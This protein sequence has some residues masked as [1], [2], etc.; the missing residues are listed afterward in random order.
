MLYAY[1]KTFRTIWLAGRFGGGKTSLA[2]ALALSLV[3]DGSCK[4]IASNVALTV[5]ELVR[6]ADAQEIRDVRDCAILLDEAWSVLGTGFD[7][8]ARDWL[9]YLRKRNQYLLMPSVLPL[10]RCVRTLTVERRFNG[11]IFGLPVWA[12]RWRLSSGT[13]DEKGTYLWWRPKRIF[14]AFDT[15]GEPG[16]EWGIYEF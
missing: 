8:N 13:G 2:V 12:Y 9:A 14:G 3:R 4:F 1:V 5:G 15:L 7:K 16:D 10:A 11:L 6:K